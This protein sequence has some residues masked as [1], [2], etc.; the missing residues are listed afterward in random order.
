MFSAEEKWSF[1][2]QSARERQSDLEESCALLEKFQTAEG[3]LSQ[4]LMEKQLLMSVL[5]PLSID[6]NMLDNQKQQVQV[7]SSFL[8]P[9][10]F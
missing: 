9:H 1:V 2:T 8:A 6:P 3:Q 10:L 7:C 4:W 5:G